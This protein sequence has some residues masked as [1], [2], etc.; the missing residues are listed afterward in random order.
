MRPRRA[1]R[2]A[3]GLRYSMEEA[4]PATAEERDGIER[5]AK[6]KGT[7]L[8]APNGQDTKLTPKQW[9]TVRTAAFKKWFGDWEKSATLAKSFRE[10]DSNANIIR[11]ERDGYTDEF[12]R[13]QEES[14]RLS[15]EDVS[16]FHGRVKQLTEDERR[17][18]ADVYGRLLAGS[19]RSGNG[20]W[21]HL[22]G[23]SGNT[24]RIARVNGELFHDIF[25]INRKYLPNGELVDLHDDYSN[26]KCFLTDDGMCGFAVEEGG[27]LVSVFSLNPNEISERKGFLYAEAREVLN[28]KRL[29]NCE[30]NITNEAGNLVATFN[31]TGYRKEQ[32]LPFAP[33][34][35]AQRR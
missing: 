21:A 20:I 10:E 34:E 24:F 15:Q 23:K 22:T 30:V 19:S 31:G 3:N 12:R 35:D 13:I 11:V 29:A 32:T 27:N 6:A 25:E 9:V 17:A 28:K 26:A 8:K 7:W 33:I 2:G 14:N 1:R 18:L 5:E 16:D 4:F